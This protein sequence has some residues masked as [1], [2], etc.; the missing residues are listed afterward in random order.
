MSERAFSQDWLVGW[1]SKEAHPAN[2]YGASS[3]SSSVL[4][5]FCIFIKIVFVTLFEWHTSLE[6]QF[7]LSTSVSLWFFE[8]FLKMKRNLGN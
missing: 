7:S 8:K 4:R 5:F 2:F 6:E 1:C 3:Y